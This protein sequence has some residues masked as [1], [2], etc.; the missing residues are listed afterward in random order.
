MSAATS[1]DRRDVTV[2][3]DGSH[4]DAATGRTTT[5]GATPDGAT[6]GGATTGDATPDGARTSAPTTDGAGRADDLAPPGARPSPLLHAT[7]WYRREARLA[8]WL[9]VAGALVL[10][11]G[12]TVVG[13]VRDGRQDQAPADLAREAMVWLAVGA[14]VG[15]PARLR[16]HVAAGMTRRTFAHAT[17]LASA[18]AALRLGAVAGLLMLA[19]RAL[20]RRLG[21]D[22]DVASSVLVDADSPGWTVVAVPLVGTLAPVSAALL[23][24]MTVQRW[25]ARALLALPVTFVPGALTLV[26]GGWV[27]R[28]PTWWPAD[29]GARLVLAFVV[30][31]A[32]GAL[33]AAAYRAVAL[34]VQVRPTLA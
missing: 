15:L 10:V 20:H 27:E 13:L 16:P 32:V 18:A 24:G 1:K 25:G 30:P 4:A 5:G 31:L 26:A 33:N 17:L 29:D 6:T 21:W 2:A 23:V 9:L 7:R 19:E 8:E 12:A 34:G 28:F 14:A 3:A 11:V 22:W